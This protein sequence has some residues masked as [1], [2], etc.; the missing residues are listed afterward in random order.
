MTNYFFFPF[1]KD[2]VFNKETNQPGLSNSLHLDG[3]GQADRKAD[4]NPGGWEATGCHEDGDS[5]RAGLVHL[6]K[7]K[8]RGFLLLPMT[9]QQEGG[10]KLEPDLLLVLGGDLQL[11]AE[12]WMCTGTGQAVMDQAGTHKIQI[13]Y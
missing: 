13:R 12:A 5:P 8:Q 3:L 1:L 2:L 4:K 11:L 10:E 7:E 6:G 9:P